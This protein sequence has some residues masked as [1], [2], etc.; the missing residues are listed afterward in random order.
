[1]LGEEAGTMFLVTLTIGM[2]EMLVNTAHPQY[3]FSGRKA[4]MPAG[5]MVN[6]ER[7]AYWQILIQPVDP[8]RLRRY[9]QD[10]ADDDPSLARC[11]GTI[12]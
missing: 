11:P 6:I 9:L 10:L 4:G 12:I 8:G 3:D 5:T 1:L 7:D 2:W